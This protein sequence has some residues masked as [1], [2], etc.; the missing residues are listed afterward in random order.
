MGILKSPMVSY[1]P[2]PHAGPRKNLFSL[3]IPRY[4]SAPR[5]PR[6]PQ[7]PRIHDWNEI[8]GRKERKFVPGFCF[9]V[10]RLWVCKTM[11]GVETLGYTTLK[12]TVYPSS[13][14]IASAAY[15]PGDIDNSCEAL[16]TYLPKV[17][18]DRYPAFHVVGEAGCGS[19]ILVSR[20]RT[21]RSFRH[22]LWRWGILGS[23]L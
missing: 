1:P 15:Q 7:N 21:R 12:E 10:C 20:V 9:Y 13:G 11:G 19:I 6:L 8:C 2:V 18:R 4:E 16:T 5:L 22:T 14:R 23:W 3:S 17:P